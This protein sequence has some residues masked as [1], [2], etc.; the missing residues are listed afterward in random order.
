MSRTRNQG[1]TELPDWLLASIPS[2]CTF[3][4]LFIACITLWLASENWFRLLTF[5]WHFYTLKLLTLTFSQKGT[6]FWGFFSKGLIFQYDGFLNRFKLIS[7]MKKK[8]VVKI[9]L[10]II[11]PHKICLNSFNR[12]EPGSKWSICSHFS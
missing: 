5:F 12:F 7:F 4:L 11:Y 8:N 9:K 2:I 6:K 3:F 1:E 10:L